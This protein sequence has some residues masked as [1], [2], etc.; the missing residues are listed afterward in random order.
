MIYYARVY[1]GLYRNIEARITASGSRFTLLRCIVAP[2]INVFISAASAN[3]M[4]T[5]FSCGG[6]M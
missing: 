6:E 2:A 4:P 3:I 5:G 1:N